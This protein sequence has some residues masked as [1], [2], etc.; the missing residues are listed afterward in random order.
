M[1]NS[2]SPLALAAAFAMASTAHAA[3]AGARES[4]HPGGDAGDRH[5]NA[6]HLGGPHANDESSLKINRVLLSGVV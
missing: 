1:Q 6:P 3:H 5:L 2:F 4:V